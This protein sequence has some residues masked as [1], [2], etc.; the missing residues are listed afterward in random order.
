[1]R[2]NIR[3]HQ[4]HD[5]ED[6]EDTVDDAGNGGQKIDE[7]FESVRNPSGGQFRKKNGGADA[8]RYGHEQRHRGGDQR[9]VNEGQRAKLIENGVP[10][11]GVE[12]IEAE[13]V[14]R[15]NGALPQYENEQQGD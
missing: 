5:D 6:A 12:K 4:G 7:E 10:Y 9:A 8:Y 14:A 11:R 2:L 15:E 1:C 13:L 3:A